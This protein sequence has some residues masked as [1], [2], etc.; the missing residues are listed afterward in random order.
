M[1]IAVELPA[2]PPPDEPMAIELG[3]GDRAEFRRLWRMVLAMA[4]RDRASSVYWHPWQEGDALSYVVA[5][6]RY[7]LVRP[8]AEPDSL[9]LAAARELIGGG[10][11]W[12]VI[13]GWLRSPVAGRFTCEGEHG[14]SEWCGVWWQAGG[15]CGAEFHRLDLA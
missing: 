4:V 2:F 11:V 9:T 10:R 5:G 14:R 1:L 3:G 7:V 15:V 13:A 6:I 8:P 12:S